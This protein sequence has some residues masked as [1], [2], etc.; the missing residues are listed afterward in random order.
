MDG[1]Q[2]HWTRLSICHRHRQGLTLPLGFRSRIHLDRLK[3]SPAILAQIPRKALAVST[4]N[5]VNRK[6]LRWPHGTGS[7]RGGGARRILIIERVIH[8]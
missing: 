8:A 6:C 3:Q 2:L 4:G 7:R 1:E 5:H